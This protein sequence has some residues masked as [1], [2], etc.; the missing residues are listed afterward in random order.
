MRHGQRPFR[1]PTGRALYAHPARNVRRPHVSQV[2]QQS[3]Q[4]GSV[5]IKLAHK[6]NAV[7]S[8]TNLYAG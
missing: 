4:L 5:E 1:P 3:L 6:K 7:F 8:H 2:S